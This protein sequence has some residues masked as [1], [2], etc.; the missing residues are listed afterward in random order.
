MNQPP[1]DQQL[2]PY[3]I[4]GARS[5]RSRCKTCRRNISKGGLRLG[6]LVEGPYGAGHMWHHLNCAARRHTEQLEEAYTLEAWNAAKEPPAKIPTLASLQGLAQEADA[7]RRERPSIPYAEIDP[8]G[9]ARCKQCGEKLPKDRLRVVLGRRAEFGSQT[10]T[11]PIQVHPACVPAAL[12]AEDTD[13]RPEALAEGLRANS[14][15]IP[16]ADV[17]ALL[18]AIGPVD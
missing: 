2:P 8:S 18:A 1:E 5:G 12:L 17:E 3:I 6:I 15:G 10:R 7:K 14:R 4:E 13:T 11:A 16:D 9:R